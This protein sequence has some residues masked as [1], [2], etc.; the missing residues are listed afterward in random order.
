MNSL[1]IFAILALVLFSGLGIF[2]GLIRSI[3]S[4]VAIIA[5]L[6]LAKKFSPVLSDFFTY[7]H[8]PTTTGLVG[9]FLIF[10]FFFIAIKIG[11]HLIQKFTQTSG[12]SFFDRVL[13]GLL[14]LA[15]GLIIAVFVFTVMQLV[16]PRNAA[17]L[18]ESS[19]LPYSNKIVAAS[20]AVV[21]HDIYSHIHRGKK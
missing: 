1:D 9:F 7:L 10:F 8:L 17:I 12:L 18:K 4:L 5:G 15:K 11:L 6:F 20:K 13:G 19:F 3:S 16:L 21:P 2:Q 14:G